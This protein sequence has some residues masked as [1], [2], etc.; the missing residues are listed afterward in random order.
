MSSAGERA[1][2]AF[3][4]FVLDVRNRSLTAPDGAPLEIS[5]RAFETLQF[6]ASHPHELVDKHRLMAAVWPNRVVEENNLS[7]QIS[8]L[9]KLLGETPDD[10]RFIVTVTGQGYRFVCDVERLD[11]SPVGRHAH[12]RRPSI[13]R[14][15]GPAVAAAGTAAL[16]L[17][18][19]TAFQ[20]WREARTAGAPPRVVAELPATGGT[21]N[22]DAYDA[23]LAAH[24]VTNS[25]GTALARDAIPLLERAVELDPEFALAWA[26]LAEAYT[27]AA[28]FPA[29]SA[30]QLTA[31]EIEQR[32]SRA[33]LRAFELAP[34]A[35]QTLRSA[36]MVSMQSRDWLEAER[37]LRRA[38]ELAGPYDYD[39]NLLY[40]LFLMNVG[41]GTEARAYVERA[42][43]AEP[44]LLRPVTFMAAL[45]EM[46]GELDEAEALL[47]S[48]S[49]LAGDETMLRNALV[50][51]EL[52]R[53]DRAGLR[54]VM[55]EFGLSTESIDDSPR[56][57]AEL[58]QLFAAAERDGATANLLPLAAF[59]S[60]HG[61]NLLALEMLS[62][63]PPTQNLHALWRPAL[64][65]L[66]QQPGFDLVVE[67]LGLAEYWQRSGNWGDFCHG[68]PS[69]GF[70]CE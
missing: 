66:R 46:R 38:V 47:R 36:G 32:I 59:A 24:A 35:P 60:F 4:G 13:G 22:V 21:R 1:I 42:M 6:L 9:R 17:G 53:G 25:G 43:R 26:A 23:Y 8:T 7:Q 41:R 33:A 19:V 57:L 37:R 65:E 18:A 5:S 10:H 70:A 31:A 28:D 40:A 64:R 2:L 20:A 3:G 45:H 55:A 50:M 27:Y 63:L 58:R 62:A 14:W 54:R 44:L 48:S 29:S 68:T 16:T 15:L 51:I 52:G 39:A 34:D 30:F 69:G 49:N 67:R 11:A 12:G 56:A 61:D